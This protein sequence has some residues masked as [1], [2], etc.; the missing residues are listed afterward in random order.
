MD[1]LGISIPKKTSLSWMTALLFFSEH[2]KVALQ[3][4]TIA[5][6]RARGL[7]SVFN[8]GI[9]GDEASSAADLYYLERLVKFLLW[10]RGEKGERGIGP[11]RYKRFH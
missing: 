8:T 5:L 6:E 2:R 9:I 3:P 4:F 11:Y 7:V 1:F 10:S